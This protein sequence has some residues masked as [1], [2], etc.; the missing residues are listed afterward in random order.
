MAYTRAGL[1]P[2]GGTSWILPRLVGLRRALELTLRNRVLDAEEARG[3]GLVAEVHAADQ[4]LPRA[5]ALALELAQGPTEAFAEAKRLL[6]QS[7]HN[8]LPTQLNAE[9]AGVVGAFD[10]VDGQEGARAFA[11][12]RD[13]VFRGRTPS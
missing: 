6:R 12:R 4:L 2:D 5:E 11:E 7:F 1:T 8:D 13:P 3:L 10:T 9:G